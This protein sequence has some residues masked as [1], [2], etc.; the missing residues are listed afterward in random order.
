MEQH[1]DTGSLALGALGEALES[2]A[3]QHLRVCGR[4]QHE[5]ARMTATVS[6]ARSTLGERELHSPPAHVWHAV[7]RQT[8][9]GERLRTDPL[10]DRRSVDDDPAAPTAVAVPA[11]TAPVSSLSE[12]RERRGLRRIVV[13]LATAAAATALIAGVAVGWQALAPRDSGMV[14]ASAN[15]DAL[16]AWDGAVGSAEIVVKD[17]GERVVRIA[18][19]A[20]PVSDAV[21]EVWLLTPEVDGLIS[22]GLL[23]DDDGEFVI[24][25]EVDL[26]RYSVVDISA[27]P[28]DGD[29]GHSGNSIVR[30]ALQS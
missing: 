20:P 17:D 19:D 21:H 16:P 6:V 4:C 25:P 12:A 30:G 22:L 9:L 15:L 2:A 26:D 29:P 11:F 1:C 3:E 27:E 10:A 14:L 8:E 13:P 5:L 23:A 24:P 18:L 7:H 28:L